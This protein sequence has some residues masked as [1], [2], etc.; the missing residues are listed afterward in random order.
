MKTLKRNVASLIFLFLSTAFIHAQDSYGEIRGLIKNT[1]MELIPFATVKILQGSQLIGGTQSDENGFYKYKPLR[2]GSYEVVFMDPAHVTQ[3]INKVKVIPDDAT[4]LDVKLSPNILGVVTVT[5][6]AKDY[7]Q[8]GADRNMYT[9]MSIEGKDLVQ[10]AGYNAGDVIGAIPSLISDVVEGPGGELHFRGSRS[11][12][13][14]NYVDGVKTYGQT[15]VPGLAIENLTIFSG[16]VPAMYGDVTSG[17]VIITTKSYFSG[18]RDKNIRN[19]EY[20]ERTAEQKRQ[21]LA[22]E[23]DK[24]RLKEIEL[25]KAKKSG[26]KE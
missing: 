8:S 13:S 3:Q 6:Q 10:M 1:E 25:E 11:D 4:Y 15:M 26:I 17:L 5:A 21:K 7:S 22:E 18:I 14:S 9:M 24:K 23:E 12:A 19:A 20:R 2:P 16:G